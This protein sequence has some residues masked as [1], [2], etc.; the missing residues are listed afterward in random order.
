M[1]HFRIN[2]Q[3]MIFEELF[4]S[5]RRNN[6]NI[7]KYIKIKF[8][9][10]YKL[11]ILKLKTMKVGCAKIKVNAISQ[12]NS[13]RTFSLPILTLQDNLSIYKAVYGSESLK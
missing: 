13:Y 12:F 10:K 11:N 3:N 1:N 8:Y 4:P 7:I 6:L 9:I 5:H 2:Y